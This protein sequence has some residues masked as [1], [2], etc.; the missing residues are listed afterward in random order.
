MPYLSIDSQGLIH[1]DTSIISVP[2]T[3][4]NLVQLLAQVGSS[5]PKTI[6]TTARGDWET[7]NSKQQPTSAIWQLVFT[8]FDNCPDCPLLKTPR[9]HHGRLTAL[10][11]R[12]IK[13][14]NETRL[15]DSKVN[16]SYSPWFNIHTFP[17]FPRNSKSSCGKVL[18]ILFIVATWKWFHSGACMTWDILGTLG[19][20]LM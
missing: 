1:P 11:P 12:N 20:V 9:W 3:P 19:T 17:S 4:S 6:E 18:F 16:W 14:C 5:V 13:L 15:M 2:S 8:C 7:A 10:G